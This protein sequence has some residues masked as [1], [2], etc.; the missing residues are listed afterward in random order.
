MVPKKSAERVIISNLREKHPVCY[1]QIAHCNLKQNT[2]TKLRKCMIYKNLPLLKMA[3]MFFFKCKLLVKR[4]ENY[5][6]FF[7]FLFK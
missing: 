1:C 7:Y 5:G 3:L 4:P 6:D 2:C